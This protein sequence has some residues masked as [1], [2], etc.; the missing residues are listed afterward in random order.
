[1]PRNITLDAS[2]PILRGIKDKLDRELFHKTLTVLA[3][4]TVAHK[5]GL[6]VKSPALK[7]YVILILSASNDTAGSQ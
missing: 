2:P 4:R 6:I 1:M 3:A 7:G 5:T